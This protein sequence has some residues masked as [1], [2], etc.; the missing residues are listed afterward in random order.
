VETGKPETPDLPAWLTQPATREVPRASPI[1]PS[2]AFDDEI[3]GLAHAAGSA[4]DRQ[5]AL[6]RGRIVH[7]LMQALPDIAPPRRQDAAAQYLA[8]AAGSFSPAERN[9][10]ARQ[11]LDLID[12]QRFAELFTPG[13]RAEV[14]IIGRI[15]RAQAEP[16]AVA[17]QV[18][19]LC[20][21]DGTVLIADYKTDRAVPDQAADV[22]APYVTQLALYRA[23]LARL[24]PKKSIRAALV[25]TGGPALIEVPVS[26]MDS[27]L[28][29]AL[30]SALAAT[31]AKS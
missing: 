8:G 7:R 28:D 11:V 5:R 14:P 19:R 3:G 1:A 25:F 20:V 30:D 23:V 12:D 16:M 13:S 27:A 9:D 29:I 10:I 17:G 18:D 24:Y 6:E 4:A 22:P 2:S 26:A 21:T 31:F 15:A